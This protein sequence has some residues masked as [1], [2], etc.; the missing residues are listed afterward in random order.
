MAFDATESTRRW[1]AGPEDGETEIKNGVFGSEEIEVLD[2]RGGLR[3]RGRNLRCG[4]R[5]CFFAHEPISI[6]LPK[7]LIE[8][9]DAQPEKKAVLIGS[10]LQ[11]I[12][13]RPPL[14]TVAMNEWIHRPPAGGPVECGVGRRVEKREDRRMPTQM[15]DGWEPR[16]RNEEGPRGT[17]TGAPAE[18]RRSRVRGDALWT[19]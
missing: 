5:R 8:G 15:E 11:R 2:P 4:R 6:N 3:D 16:E 9:M 17:S 13:R 12:K 18:P 19:R 7:W 1:S 10:Y 14:I